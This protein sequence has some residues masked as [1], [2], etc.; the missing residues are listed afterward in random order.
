[1]RIEKQIA[2]KIKPIFAVVV[3]G[4]AREI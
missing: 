2:I 3:D 1:M 4:Q